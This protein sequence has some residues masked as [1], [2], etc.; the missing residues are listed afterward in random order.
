MKRI[1]TLLILVTCFLGARAQVLFYQDF[2]SGSIDPMTAVD[3]DGKTVNPSVANVAGPTFG[4]VQQTAKNKAVVSTSWFDP[5]G[6]ADDWLISPPITITDANTFL[7]WEAYS[8]DAN[9]RDGYQVRVS[10]TD[11]AIASFSNLA[12]N[13]AA[14]LT[15]WTKRSA[16]L[17]AYVGQTIYF[18]FRN[19]SNDKYLLFMDN[20]KVEVLKGN[21]MI[22]KNL[23]FDKYNPIATEVPV[24]ISIENHGAN[25]LTSFFFDYTVEGNTYTD[26]IT[27]LNVAPLKSTDV[28]HSLSY[29]IAETGEFP[30][31]VNISKPNG[32]ADEDSLDNTITRYIYGLSQALPKKV[33]VE[34]ATG[35]WCQWCPRGAVNM[36]LIAANYADVAMPVAVHNADPMTIS[37]YDGPFSQSVGGYPSGHVDRK[38]R[39]IDPADFAANIAPMQERLVP[40]AVTTNVTY[41]AEN[42]IA[43][44]KGTAHT[45]IATQSNGLRFTTI[46]T[47]NNVTGADSGYDQVNTYSGGANGPMGGFEDLPNPVPADQ[48][49]YNYVARAIIGGFEGMENS[50]PDAT[51]AG[52][53]FEFEVQYT[54]PTDYNVDEM[55]AI[56]IVQDEETGEVLNGDI[57]KLGETTSVPL[58]PAGHFTAYPNP[59]T[60]VLNLV[61]DYQYD[62][63]VSMKIY[64]PLGQLVRDLGSLDLTNGNQTA[65]IQVG[66]LNNGNYILELRDKNAVTALPF[67]K[68]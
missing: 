66:D 2:E 58:V 6:Q 35:T 12:L 18:A 48:M 52:E 29:T 20:I 57:Q 64:T 59:T 17:S 26:T 60:D 45:S 15:T 65:A 9:F 16:K 47:E 38:V 39:D 51:D 19:N 7:S 50:V 63:K 54:V 37:E 3:V 13:V 46:I 42:R 8:P 44:I 34:E 30:I 28:T 25:P 55:K 53:D 49:I 40:V 67:T 61:V 41:D 31:A 68:M 24:K 27:G 5:V 22:V 62:A 33:L 32:V 4:I 11:N 10:T 36:D 43:T 1:L 14:E 23:T 21:N 56:V